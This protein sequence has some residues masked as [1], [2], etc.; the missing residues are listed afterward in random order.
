MSRKYTQDHEWI[1]ARDGGVFRVGVSDYAQEQ[2]GD[3]VTIEPPEIGRRLAK[4]EE[5]AVIESV[6]AAS[7]VFAP[8]AGE[9]VAANEALEED[10]ALVNRDAEG[11]GWLFEIRADD[12]ES[13]LAGLLDE[14]AYREFVKDA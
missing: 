9:I 7:E 11:E 2:L 12:P 1:E 3:I 6:K 13:D 10:P 14:A 4:G 8:L 5:C